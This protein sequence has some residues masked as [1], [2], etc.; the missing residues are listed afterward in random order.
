MKRRYVDKLKKTICVTLALALLLCAGAGLLRDELTAFALNSS[1][2]SEKIDG[3]QGEIS[4]TQGRLNEITG[5]IDDLE[6]EAD[7]LEEQIDDLNSELIN[8]MTEIAI[9]EDEISAKNLEIQEKM[10]QVADTKAEYQ[11]AVEREDQQYADMVLRL[12]A[13]Y[14]RREDD[15]ISLLLEGEGLSDML[16]RATA[17]EK[18]YEYDRDKLTQLTE[19]RQ[20][21]RDLWD[22]LETEEAELKVQR[23]D[24]EADMDALEEQ[25]LRLDTLQTKLR[26]QYADYEARIR[27][28]KQEAAVAKSLLQQEQ[29]E[30]RDLQQQRRAALAAEA[31]A[32]AAAAA[33]ASASGGGQ[34]PTVSV[35]SDYASVVD[36][37][38]GSDLGKQIAKY[39]LQF[40]GNPYVSGGTSLT[41]GADCSGFTYRI[42]ANYGYSIPRTSYQQRSA[43]TGVEYANA[44]PG[45]IICYEGHVAMYIGGGLIVH[46]SNARSGIKVSR[47]TY[48]SIITVRRILG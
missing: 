13:M 7:V 11:A 36:S 48:R 1:Q 34:T 44:Q 3:K 31:A 8:T 2:I 27:Q 14:E 5:R 37:A 47:A 26:T 30:L 4:A 28:A 45:D 18:V 41:N 25:K 15:P 42:Y 21:V 33:A 40:V 38:S 29:R 24:L 39:A 10:Q 32:A 12:R 46:A 6:D 17:I 20:Q 9:K 16:S 19:T 35:T 23:A 22:L 43:G